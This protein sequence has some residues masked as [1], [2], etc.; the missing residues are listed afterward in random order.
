MVGTLRPLDAFVKSA[1]MSGTD[2]HQDLGTDGAPESVG[3]QMAANQC[4]PLILSGP[5]CGGVAGWGG[6]GGG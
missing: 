2:S 5:L 6:A 3:V 4:P 1:K